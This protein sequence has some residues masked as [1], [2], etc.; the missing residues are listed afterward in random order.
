MIKHFYNDIQGWFTFKDLYDLV[1]RKNS[2]GNH[3]VEVG[4]WKGH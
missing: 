4:A 1:L 3:F 2:N